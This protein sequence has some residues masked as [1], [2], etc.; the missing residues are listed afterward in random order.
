M[1]TTSPFFPY[2]NGH[3]HPN[4][5]DLSKHRCP[6]WGCP[7]QAK[8]Q[9]YLQPG[10]GPQATPWL[11]PAYEHHARSCEH[12]QPG[13]PKP[14]VANFEKWALAG[15]GAIALDFPKAWSELTTDRGNAYYQRV[16]GD[17]RLT[18]RAYNHQLELYVGGTWRTIHINSSYGDLA[19]QARLAFKA[20]EKQ[21]G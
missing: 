3:R 20:Y 5:A 15:K 19:Y 7:L 2:Q 10:T 11:E 12:H 16:I 17:Y 4:P 9:R 1:P 14:H 21:V 6:G 18:A 13:K 8:C